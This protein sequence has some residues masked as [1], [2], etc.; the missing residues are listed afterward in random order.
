[1]LKIKDFKI[2]SGLEG[3]ATDGWYMYSNVSQ[4]TFTIQ[5]DVETDV[6]NAAE[7][8]RISDF[9][10]SSFRWCTVTQQSQSVSSTKDGVQIIA[11]Y[12]IDRS[13]AISLDP[14]Y[15]VYQSVINEINIYVTDSTN[16]D[17]I[18]KELY[19]FI[20]YSIHSFLCI[21]MKNYPAEYISNKVTKCFTGP[22][23]YTELTILFDPASNYS[24]EDCKYKLYDCYH[25]VDEDSY[26]EIT[27]QIIGPIIYQKKIRDGHY[28][29]GAM[30][31]NINGTLYNYETNNV[32]FGCIVSALND[33][34]DPNYTNVQMMLIY[35]YD[36][37][38][39]LR[40]QIR[41][42]SIFFSTNNTVSIVSYIKYLQTP[43]P[44]T[45]NTDTLHVWGDIIAN[46][47][48]DAT[49]R[50]TVA[51]AT[52]TTLN[53][54]FS[55][56]TA[57]QGKYT[58]KA[59]NTLEDTGITFGNLEPG[60]IYAIFSSLANNVRIADLRIRA[61]NSS[62]TNIDFYEYCLNSSTNMFYALPVF[63]CRANKGSTYGDYHLW[64]SCTAT[65]SGT[66]VIYKILGPLL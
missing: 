62:G 12:L 10:A 43:T 27:N 15:T 6:E 64:V 63:Y 7:V 58:T 52:L 61:K 32:T 59:A 18:K 35:L 51:Q 37:H 11:N 8:V 42:P 53:D 33:F 26:E 40:D 48:T 17:V 49:S 5:V 9:D 13:E 25:L 3:N 54:I 22:N 44:L 19:V 21:S 57:V 55:I 60:A 16:T 39:S 38:S 46:N 56:E 31:Y 23:V 2:I 14:R 24:I 45:S 41:E 34:S 66:Y 30:I 28:I 4:Y 1:M 50:L 20:P 29:V 36:S 47:I 65:G